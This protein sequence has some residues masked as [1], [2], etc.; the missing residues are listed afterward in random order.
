[1]MKLKQI[2]GYEYQ[3]EKWVRMNPVL[4]DETSYR[5]MF[6]SYG[7]WL[8]IICKIVGH[9]MVYAKEDMPLYHAR[10]AICKYEIVAE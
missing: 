7:N 2:L 5:Y 1:M 6:N 3:G 4:Y 8:R 9:K 10:C